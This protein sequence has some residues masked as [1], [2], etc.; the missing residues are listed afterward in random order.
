MTERQCIE[1]EIEHND[2]AFI[3]MLGHGKANLFRD[4]NRRREGLIKKLCQ[5]N[6]KK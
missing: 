5:L 2:K 6:K 4:L 1:Q 3:L